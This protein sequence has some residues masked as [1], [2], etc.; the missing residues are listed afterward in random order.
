MTEATERSMLR[1]SSTSIWATATIINSAESIAIAVRFSAPIMRGLSS[2]TGRPTAAMAQMRPNSRFR[3]K[4]CRSEA[5]PSFWSE[6]TGS[7]AASIVEVCASP[8]CCV[9]ATVAERSASVAARITRSGSTSSAENRAVT[10]PSRS[11]TMRSHIPTSS[12]NSDEMRMIAMPCRASSAIIA[13]T[14]DLLWTSMPCVGSSRI[15]TRGR[16]ASHLERTTF[17]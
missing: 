8:I 2:M 14:S 3:S 4:R 7:A 13:C 9:R 11:T 17:C 15:R 16:V 10:R 6:L 1:V 5:Y 12:G